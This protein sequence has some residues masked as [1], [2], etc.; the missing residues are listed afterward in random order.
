[1]FVLKMPVVEKIRDHYVPSDYRS[2]RRLG[3]YAWFYLFYHNN[4]Y[5]Y[6]VH[7]NVMPYFEEPMGSFSLYKRYWLYSFRLPFI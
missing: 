6:K 7:F 4:Y 3:N 5:Y 1:M 2:F